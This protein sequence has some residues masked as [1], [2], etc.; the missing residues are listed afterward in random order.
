MSETDP[1]KTGVYPA[2]EVNS[3]STIAS[4]VVASGVAL[5]ALYTGP[6]LLGEYMSKLA[7]NES[8]AGFI[9]SMEMA[10]LTLGSVI[11]FAISHFNWRR[12]LS[13]SLG[14]MI[15][16]NMALM[17]VE[18]L[19]VFLVCR[20]IAGLGSGMVMTLTIQVV[21]MMQDPDR[22]YGMW[23]LGQLSLGT[24][25]LMFFPAVIEIS[26]I[27]TVFLIWAIMALV[28]VPSIRFYPCARDADLTAGTPDAG[29]R[30]TSLGLLCLAG[31]FV[32]YGGQAGVWVYLERLGVSWG[33]A[34]DSVAHILFLS[35][36]AAIAGAVL[37][38]LL[39]HS[40]GRVLPLS[41]SMAL[42]ATSILFLI[43]SSGVG[44][45]TFAACLFNFA[46]YLFL[47]Y[48][49]AIIAALD[50]NGR[51]L[52]GLA[53]TF[54]AGLAAGPAIAALLIGS[55]ENLV[56]CLVYGLVSVP[57]GL[58]LILPGA[59]FRPLQS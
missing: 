13:A 22:V 34:G 1:A 37:A 7:V 4:V 25:G 57:I 11:F 48:V 35:L 29:R 41:L 54:P 14:L 23:T 40:L 15:V 6:L 53:V 12:I 9:I 10:G 24:L 16:A 19:P 8:Q 32:Y 42:S 27:N 26:N 44:M 49:S 43:F 59:G 39:G 2:V 50:Q 20:F 21:G 46:W 36:L 18:N 33:I 30:R 3:F 52:T 51:L 56:A 47:P 28:L 5:F 17:L 58:A 45:F 31:L 55:S 38:I